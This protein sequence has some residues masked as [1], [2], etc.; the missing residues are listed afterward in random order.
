MP[1]IET[2]KAVVR[3]VLGHYNDVTEVLLDI[4][5]DVKKAINYEN[6]TGN[7]KVGDQVIVNTTA[8]T[9]NLGTG[10]YHFVISNVSY[11]SKHIDKDGHGMK[12]KYT[13]MQIKC[14]LT[15]EC[16]NRYQKYFNEPV[17]LSKGLIYIGEL[18]SMLPPLCAGLKYYSKG[19]VKIAYIMTDH[20][21][22]PLSF[23][24]SV[25]TLKNKNLLNTTI[26]TGN[27]FGGDYECVNIYT[28]IITAFEIAKCDVVII[29]M[30]P[31]ILGTQT[32][33]GF[34]GLEL[35]LYVDM[36]AKLE[37]RCLYIP[38]IM[39]NDKRNRHLGI[40]HHSITILSEIIN[41]PVPIILP[42]ME[43]KQMKYVYRQLMRNSL[44]KKHQVKFIDGKGITNAIKYYELFTTTMGRGIYEEPVFFHTLGA[45]AA[46]G[47]SIV[48]N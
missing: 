16:N 33:Y 37:G 9:L 48:S 34:S 36:I 43:T 26:T 15:E 2:K 17:D 19:R 45:S 25:L 32:K 28:S 21:A 24:K 10:G 38:R 46:F 47:L 42:I 39:F 8:C 29:T 31:G 11:P 5:H 7:I 23:S 40:S 14:L 27:A 1:E 18:H 30:G 13:P 44:T 20:G 3:E 4:E 22:L 35:G 12:M 6:I 41:N